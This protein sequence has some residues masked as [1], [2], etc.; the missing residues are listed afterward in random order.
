MPPKK[1]RARVLDVR[2]EF[3]GFLKVSRYRIETGTHAGGA[4]VVERQ[5]MERGH[6]VAI[7]GYDPVRDEVLLVN[8]MRAGPL[9]AKDD[10][11]SDALPAGMI[12]GN[13]TALQAARR[14]MEEETG[15]KLKNARVS[16]TPA[17]TSVP[18]ARRNAS[19]LSSASSTQAG[20]AASTARHPNPKT[21][22][23]SSSRQMNSSRAPKAA[24]STT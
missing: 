7:L 2:T 16:S 19:R 12:D 20:R 4:R 22:N 15:L 24:R 11:F 6:A 21:S 18:A 23:P 9:A 5:V 10:A 13:E 17:P 8:E 1:P 3:N 14:E